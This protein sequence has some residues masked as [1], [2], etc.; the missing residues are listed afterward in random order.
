MYLRITHTTHYEFENPIHY[1]VQQLRLTPKD[2]TEQIVKNWSITIDQGKIETEFSDH[3]SNTVSLLSLEAGA[4]A[5]KVTCQ[6]EVETQDTAG[7]VGHQKGLAPLWLFQR[8]T[9]L[10]R[11]SAKVRRLT[12]GLHDEYK[13]DVPLLHELSRR[14]LQAVPYRIG[15]TDAATCADAAIENG[16]GVCQDHAHIFVACARV[17]GFPARYVSG[18]LMMEDRLHQDATHA[19]AEAHVDGV[20]WIGFDVSNSISPDERYVRIATGLDY[21]DAAPLAGLRFGGGN[22]ALQ[23]DVAVQPQ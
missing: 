9:Q 22:E 5:I 6:G 2:R 19:W 15:G 18:Y 3:Y 1:G 11:N 17:M 13:D 23:V 20:G 10:T 12:K 21:R 14:I 4:T 8:S 16:Y 7:I